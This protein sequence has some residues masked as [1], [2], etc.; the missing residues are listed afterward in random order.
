[1]NEKRILL[2]FIVYFFLKSHIALSTIVTGISFVKPLQR[3]SYANVAIFI[4]VA[5][6]A[7]PICGNVITLFIFNK[8]FFGSTVSFSTTSNPTSSISFVSKVLVQLHM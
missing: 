3:F 6:L 7:E 4:S 1:M 5:Y 2:I 8:V